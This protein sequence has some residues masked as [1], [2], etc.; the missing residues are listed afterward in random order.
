MIS[1]FRDDLIFTKLRICEYK[2]LAKIFEFTETG[3]VSDQLTY[4]DGKRKGL[5]TLRWSELKKTPSYSQGQTSGTGSP[6]NVLGQ[7]VIECEAGPTVVQ[8]KRKQ[9]L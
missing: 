6:M 9:Y 8:L 2:T 3:K 5:L 1:P 4:C 7:V